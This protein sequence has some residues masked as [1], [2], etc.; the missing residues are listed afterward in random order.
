MITDVMN[1]KGIPGLEN[2]SLSQLEP[3]KK[4]AEMDFILSNP[5]ISEDCHRLTGKQLGETLRRLDPRYSGLNL[6]DEQINGYLIGA[7]DLIFFAKGKFW[8][9]DWKSNFLDENP[10]NY[11]KSLL[12]Q[13]MDKKHYKLQYLLYLVVLKRYLETRF[14]RNDVYDL[15]GGA[16]YFFLRGIKASNPSQ[17]IY[18]DRPKKEVLD[19]LNEILRNGYSEEIVQ[20]YE[21]ELKGGNHAE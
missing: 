18:F 14:K 8:V 20:K 1:V 7:I 3:D 16:A 6:S 11:T 12:D 19:C 15:I 13:A 2:F 17:G 10:S 5:A 4:I 21:T 9:I